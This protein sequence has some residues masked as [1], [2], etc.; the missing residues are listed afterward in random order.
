MKVQCFQAIG[1]KCVNLHLYTLELEKLRAA[2]EDF[3]ALGTKSGRAVGE[4]PQI[5]GAQFAKVRAVQA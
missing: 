3:C 5:N 1:F 4:E 2:F